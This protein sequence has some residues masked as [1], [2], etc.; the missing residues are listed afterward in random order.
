MKQSRQRSRGTRKGEP[1]SALRGRASAQTRAPSPRQ[2]PTDHD[3]DGGPSVRSAN[4]RVINRRQS[5][6]GRRLLCFNHL[7]PRRKGAYHGA[8]SLE[9]DRVRVSRATAAPCALVTKKERRRYQER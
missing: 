3:H 5:H 1:S 6:F 7:Q 8:R 2:L 9:I 4:I